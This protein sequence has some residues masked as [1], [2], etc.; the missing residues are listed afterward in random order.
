MRMEASPHAG[1]GNGESAR[2]MQ[3][4]RRKRLEKTPSLEGQMSFDSIGDLENLCI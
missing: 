1:Q 2:P 3:A 4:M